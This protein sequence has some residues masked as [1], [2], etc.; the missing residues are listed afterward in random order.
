MFLLLIFFHHS[1]YTK[2]VPH[3]FPLVVYL[4]WF[5]FL[6]QYSIS[7]FIQI[8]TFANEAPSSILLPQASSKKTTD[9][10]KERRERCEKRKK[11]ENNFIFEAWIYLNNHRIWKSLKNPLFWLRSNSICTTNV[12]EYSQLNCCWGLGVYQMRGA[13]LICSNG[14]LLFLNQSGKLL[15]WD[16]HQALMPRFNW[17]YSSNELIQV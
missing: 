8:L 10:K 15:F 4:H 3:Y 13:A 7:I 12:L 16:K 11:G 5:K 17:K 9:H 1:I 2:D 14:L 6:F